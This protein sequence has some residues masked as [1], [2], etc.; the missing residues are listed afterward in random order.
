MEDEDD[1][2]MSTQDRGTTALNQ[3]LGGSSQAD[4]RREDRR[5]RAS[6]RHRVCACPYADADQCPKLGQLPPCCAAA[7]RAHI[8]VC[9]LA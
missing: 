9:V 6:D 2:D 4:R 7:E 1:L 3:G 5:M 8:W